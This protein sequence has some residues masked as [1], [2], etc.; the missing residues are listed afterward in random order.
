MNQN[1]GKV[2]IKYGDGTRAHSLNSQT[3][4]IGYDLNLSLPYLQEAFAGTLFYFNQNDVEFNGGQ[5][6]IDNFG[7]GFYLGG[8]S[9]QSHYRILLQAQYGQTKSDLFSPA[10]IINGVPQE[11]LQLNNKTDHFGA[12]LYLGFVSSPETSNPWFFEPF[13]SAHTYW[14]KAHQSNESKSIQFSTEQSHQSVVKLG[15][16]TAYRGFKNPIS[17]IYAQLTWIHRFGKNTAIVGKEQ[18]LEQAFLSEELQESWAEWSLSGSLAL[19]KNCSAQLMA[20]GGY[21]QTVK[22]RYTMSATFAYR[23]E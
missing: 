18:N 3:T 11:T 22:P 10:F 7:A 14:L 8:L 4:S 21:A 23:F 13:V 12:S 1:L 9:E 2:N 17:N 20:S 16:L 19:S 15:L 6:N 5:A